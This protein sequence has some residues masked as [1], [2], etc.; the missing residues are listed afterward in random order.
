MQY[1]VIQTVVSMHPIVLKIVLLNLCQVVKK[2][3][4]RN[5]FNRIPYPA[6][7]TKHLNKQFIFVNPT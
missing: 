2:A 4:I 5:R 1:G 6:L 3:M 7:N